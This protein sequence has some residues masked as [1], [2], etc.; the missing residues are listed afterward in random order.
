MT[1]REAARNEGWIGG[2]TNLQKQR[3]RSAEEPSDTLRS[4]IPVGK[5]LEESSLRLSQKRSSISSLPRTT[6]HCPL[7]GESLFTAVISTANL[8]LSYLYDV[9]CQRTTTIQM[10]RIALPPP[11]VRASSFSFPSSRRSQ[12]FTVCENIQWLAQQ[13]VCLDK[14]G[15]ERFCQ[16]M[17]LGGQ[18][19]HTLDQTTYEVI[20]CKRVSS[21]MVTSANVASPVVWVLIPVAVKI[22][23]SER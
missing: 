3:T 6:I 1:A 12:W 17:N 4:D 23:A 9:L 7:C 22:V 14:E 16:G 2:S 20:Y 15:T 8:Q 10:H 5:G 11:C 21:V 18:F 13:H 19:Y